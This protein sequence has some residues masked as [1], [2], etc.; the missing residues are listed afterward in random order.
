MYYL[1]CMIVIEFFFLLVRSFLSVVVFYNL[2]FRRFDFWY[3]RK[4]ED[5]LIL[6]ICR[7]CNL[8][9]CLLGILFIV[10]IVF[11]L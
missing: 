11:D 6:G 10:G 7:K 9:I 3:F 1:G 2:V 8:F 5:I 4:W